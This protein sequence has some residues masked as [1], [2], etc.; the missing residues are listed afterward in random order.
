MT[1]NVYQVRI[2]GCIRRLII[3][4]AW[5]LRKVFVTMRAPDSALSSEHFGE[6][7]GI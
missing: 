6:T 3:N 5:F 2:S 7:R 1:M 4:V